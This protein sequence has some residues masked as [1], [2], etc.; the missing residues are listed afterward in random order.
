M[1]TNANEAG[2]VKLDE[3]PPT[4]KSLAAGFRKILPQLSGPQRP[5]LV[6]LGD[7]FD[8]SF[9]TAQA[10]GQAFQRLIEEFFAEPS[11]FSDTIVYVPGNHDH[12]NWQIMRDAALLQSVRDHRFLEE[13]EL[14]VTRLDKGSRVTCELATALAQQLPGK[15]HLRVETGYPN[16]GFEADGKAVVLHHGHYTEGTYRTMSKLAELMSADM[17]DTD[18]RNIE[19]MNGPFIDFGWSST[20]DQAQIAPRLFYY[21]EMIQDPAATHATIQRLATMLIQSASRIIP[22][23]SDTKIEVAGFAASVQNIVEA[24]LDLVLARAAETER[25]SV[26]RVLSPEST[27]GVRDY[28]AGPVRHQLDEMKELG[29]HDV[30]QLSFIFGH[31]HKPFQDE[32]VVPG[33]NQPVGIWNT[34]GW[35]LDHPGLSPTQGAAAILVDDA[36]NVASLRLF[37]DPLEGSVGTVRAEGCHAPSDASNPLLHSLDEALKAN[38]GAWDGFS[39]DCL[40]AIDQRVRLLRDAYFD[41]TIH[42]PATDRRARYA[43]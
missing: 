41:P 2:E 34:G 25:S 10:A 9:V 36:A 42:P 32:M 4:L 15:E 38:A 27:S 1:L 18:I 21:Y 23:Q 30:D 24:L 16:I 43:R 11:P 29:W 40:A 7:V 6:L 19:L 12:R 26:T 33:F 13:D 14:V 3:A 5:S 22:V 35:V 20:G 8:L 37:N 28:V 17:P 31:T 39:R